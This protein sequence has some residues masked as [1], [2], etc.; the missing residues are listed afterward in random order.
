M[1]PGD[2]RQPFPHVSEARQI[3]LDAERDLEAWQPN[4]EPIQSNAAGLGANLMPMDE[5]STRGTSDIGVVE[6]T[7]ASTAIDKP[8]AE[9][10]GSHL[11]AAAA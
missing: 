4:L 6:P 1:V 5:G 8:A 11:E 2:V 3:L 7:A 10:Q 9:S